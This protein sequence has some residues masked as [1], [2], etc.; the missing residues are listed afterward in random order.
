MKRFYS[1]DDVIHAYASMQHED[2]R[3]GNVFF[4]GKSIFSYGHHYKMGLLMVKDAIWINDSGYSVST[5]KHLSILGTATRHMRQFYASGSHVYPVYQRIE[6]IKEKLG[7]ARKPSMYVEEARSLW[8]SLNEFFSWW[9]DQETPFL[10]WGGNSTWINSKESLEYREIK[11]FI[12]SLDTLEET[13]KGYKAKAKEDRAKAKKAK[14]I[15]EAR[16]E[17]EYQSAT[18]DFREYR[19]NRIYL[20]HGSTKKDVCRVSKCG[21]YIETSQGVSVSVKAAKILYALIQ[22]GKDIKGYNIEGYRVISI[23]GDL[24]I[25]CHIIDVRDVHEIGKKIS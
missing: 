20:K 4:E 5:G 22:A 16:E 6:E 14:A 23:N 18:Q 17:D 1:N 9:G 2:G 8:A 10:P 3:S 12:D 15:R 7:N 13:L 25:G 19:I 11:E 24:K 21:D